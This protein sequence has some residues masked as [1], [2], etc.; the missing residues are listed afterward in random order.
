MIRPR[1]SPDPIPMRLQSWL[2]E[3]GCFNNASKYG[4][5]HLRM[6]VGEERKPTFIHVPEHLRDEF[7]TVY[8]SS[9]EPKYLCEYVPSGGAFRMFWDIDLPC[10]PLPLG[11][12]ALNTA[13]GQQEAT[14]RASDEGSMYT[15]EEA[16]LAREWMQWLLQSVTKTMARAGAP[17][18]AYAAAAAPERAAAPAEGD[19][20]VG[21]SGWGWRCGVH[22]HVDAIVGCEGARA[23]THALAEQLIRSPWAAK[24]GPTVREADSPP[25]STRAAAAQACARVDWNAAL[26]LGVYRTGSL[27]LVGSHKVKR[28]QDAG[29]VYGL[30]AAV[31]AA[32]AAWSEADLRRLAA[33][34]PGLM[35]ALSILND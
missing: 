28:R 35:R 25:S 13:G 14:G 29:R 1:A 4:A 34:G 8:F 30:C 18:A 23:L 19:G 12:G 7:A 10:A 27:R 16:T 11:A 3:R 22:V 5:T 33:D 17:T 32:G 21:P 9:Q 2:L 31:D 6:A 20:A 15:V 26:D 24:E